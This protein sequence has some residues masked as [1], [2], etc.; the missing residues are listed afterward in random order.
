MF[1]I[2]NFDGVKIESEDAI[3][4]PDDMLDLLNTVTI[5][6]ARGVLYSELRGTYLDHAILP[7]LDP[8]AF[9]RVESI[10]KK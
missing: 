10:S 4:L 1:D 8:R 6:T 2:F 9:Q 3:S 7:V 5:G